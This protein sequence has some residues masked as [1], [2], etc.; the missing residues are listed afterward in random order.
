MYS[1]MDEPAHSTAI[2]FAHHVAGLWEDHLEDRLVGIYLLGSL[3]HGGF[4][5]RYS[6]IDMALI[7]DDPLGRSELDLIRQKAAAYSPELALKLSLFWT[8]PA[9]SV[10]RFPP[11]D[12]VDYID[13]AVT[14]IERR[15]VR[16]PHPTLQEIRAYLGAKP[17]SNWSLIVD[18]FNALDELPIDEHKRYLRSLLYPARFLYGWHAGRIAS[19]DDA[20]EFVRSHALVGPE[21]DLIVRA[22]RRRNEGLDPWPLFFERGALLRLR[23][24]CRERMAEG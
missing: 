19:N 6:D 7:A 8:D 22:L 17:F 13:H 11:L 1:A 18:R 24:I 5:A 10:G 20:V 12:R 23:N 4:S 21:L 15:R 9:F 3:A 14:L 16:P 2:A